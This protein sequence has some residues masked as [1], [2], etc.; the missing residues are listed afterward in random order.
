MKTTKIVWTLL[1]AAL[2]LGACAHPK[3]K[4]EREEGET[5][6]TREE[7]FGHLP[8][9]DYEIPNDA[10]FLKGVKICLDP[11][12]GGDAHIPRYKRGPTGVREAEMNWTTAQFLKEFLESAEAEV[13]LTRSGDEDVSLAQRARIANRAQVDFFISMHHNAAS[14]ESANFTSTWYHADP[15]YGPMNLDLSRYVQQGV[16]EALRL[17]E[18]AANPLKSD[19]LMYPDAGFGVLR[20]LEVP[21]C[22]VEA[23][24]FSNVIE[25]QRLRHPEYLKREAYGYFLGIARYVAAG[26]PFSVMRQPEPGARL[27]DKQPEIVVE[28]N[29][30]LRDRGGWGADRN[31]IFMDS[32]RVRLDG[33][34]IT[35]ATYD[36]Q[37]KAVRFKVPDKLPNGVHLVEVGF[38]NLSGNH[39]R[40]HTHRFIVA[41]PIAQIA[42]TAKPTS[43]HPDG[44]SYALVA[45][46]ASDAD[47]TPVAD[48]STLRV[49]AEGGTLEQFAVKTRAGK[50]HTYV[51]SPLEPGTIRLRVRGDEAE[52]ALAIPV[53]RDAVPLIYGQVTQQ[54]S[55]KPL[56]GIQVE[57]TFPTAE[58]AGE[59]LTLLEG[60][61]PDTWIHYLGRRRLDKQVSN[62]EGRV[63]FA[64]KGLRPEAFTLMINQGGYYRRSF[65]VQFKD[66]QRTIALNLPAYPVAG[67]ILRDKIFLLDPEGGGVETGAVDCRGNEASD[68]NLAVAE[69]LKVLLESAG[70]QARLIRTEDIYL[71]AQQRVEIASNMQVDRYLAIE[72]GLAEDA[73]SGVCFLYFPEMEGRR[74]AERASA[75][76]AA[77]LGLK[78]LGVALS[79]DAK[80]RHAA[81]PASAVRLLTMDAAEVDNAADPA[82]L[83]REAYALYQG[84]LA[85]LGLP[86]EYSAMLSLR[87]VNAQTG[88][89][90][91]GVEI[92]LDGSLSRLTDASGRCRFSSI[93]PRFYDAAARKKGY[94]TFWVRLSAAE[95]GEYVLA[96]RPEAE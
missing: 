57:L 19:Y 31:W 30:G 15:D 22:L 33:R 60:A 73:T 72:H 8:P 47:G 11:G 41:C 78:D 54:D 93:L 86:K 66:A 84:L 2:L 6:F 53:G 76:A 24:F 65:P 45:F 71:S 1:V 91:E 64:P 48:G 29:D 95:E 25:E 10:Q 55:G 56:E 36:P 20:Q 9:V 90:L 75:R 7:L 58:E 16:A 40:P 39:A 63:I 23:S 21:G 43:L 77:E 67:G 83:D 69:R 50:A 74:G 68:L 85:Q 89:P 94:E 14:R 44:V 82:W 96:L 13:L 87:A 28:L 51:H 18:V 49:E 70:A 88:L 52:A 35:D 79:G 27:Q 26:I 34:E 37:A 61:E 62:E 80:V 59:T 4:T 17:P 42:V 92:T 38:R 32:I 46:E 3:L 12:H 81:I 5:G